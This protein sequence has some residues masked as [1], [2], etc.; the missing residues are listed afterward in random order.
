[1][2][3]EI[4]FNSSEIQKSINILLHLFGTKLFVNVTVKDL[5]EGYT[6]ALIEMASLVKPGSLKDNKFGILQPVT[7]IY[8]TFS[9]KK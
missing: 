2:A 4:Q 1:M 7:D 5:M 3:H 9:Y 6:D 8:L